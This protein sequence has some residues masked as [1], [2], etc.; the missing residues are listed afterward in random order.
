MNEDIY[1]NDIRNR[2]PTFT[3]T[4]SIN[5]SLTFFELKDGSTIIARARGAGSG[6]VIFK[7]RSVVVGA[8][9]ILPIQTPTQRDNLTGLT[10][11]QHIIVDSDGKHQVEFYDGAVWKIVGGII[12]NALQA[13]R[14]TALTLT[15]SFV[16]VQLDTTDIETDPAVIEHNIQA[17]DNIDIKVTGTYEI[18][19]EA[20]VSSLAASNDVIVMAGRV[21]KNDMALEFQDQTQEQAHLMMQL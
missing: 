21:R 6:N 20:D 13:S 9:D 19:Y 1:V 18:S 10:K 4:K 17:F 11:G 7:L 16:D 3:L 5:G 8:V 2:F 15:T 14:T 12:N